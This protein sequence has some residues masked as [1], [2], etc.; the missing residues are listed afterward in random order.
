MGNQKRNRYPLDFPNNHRLFKSFNMAFRGKCVKISDRR[1][2]YKQL[3]AKTV[4]DYRV[5]DRK[6]A[7]TKQLTANERKKTFYSSETLQYYKC[8]SVA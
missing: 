6:I 4:P 2:G 7:L 1:A 3:H 5:N 8:I